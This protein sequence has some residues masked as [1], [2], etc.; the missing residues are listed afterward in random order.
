MGT[1]VD[2]V[3]HS[4]LK[5]TLFQVIVEKKTANYLELHELKKLY[6]LDLNDKI[7]P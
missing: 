4:N 7:H 2:Q 5:H 1:S 3:F 6:E